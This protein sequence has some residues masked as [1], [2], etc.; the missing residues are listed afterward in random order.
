MEKLCRAEIYFTCGA[1][2]AYVA[3]ILACRNAA[4]QLDKYDTGTVLREENDKGKGKGKDFSCPFK[5][6]NLQCIIK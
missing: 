1:Y 3:V 5:L 6:I 4:C 2:S